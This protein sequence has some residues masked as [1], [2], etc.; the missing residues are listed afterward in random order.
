MIL[1]YQNFTTLFK[2][3][4]YRLSYER[5]LVLAITISMELFP[6]YETFFSQ[7]KWGDP[8][9]LME[10]IKMCD[11]SR[12]TPIDK[13]MVTEMADKVE[14][15]T[16]HMDDYGDYIGSYALNACVAAYYS[17]QLLIDSDPI[18]IFYIGTSLTDTIDF[19]IQEEN[20]L[21]EEQIDNH[22]EMI[23]VRIFLIA[24]T[25]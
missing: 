1:T 10:A 12:T 16:P 14:A 15:I 21:T 7:Y 24:A 20:D 4:V 8:E 19:K 18:N 6:Y 5:Q 13:V 17:L 23:E 9:L 3:Q 22:P 11:Q 2:E 25:A